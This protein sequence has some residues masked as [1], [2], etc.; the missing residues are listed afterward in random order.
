LSCWLLDLCNQSGLTGAPLVQPTPPVTL[1]SSGQE[2]ATGRFRLR[3]RVGSRVRD[4]KD[5]Q[6]TQ[7]T[8]P[9]KPSF[10]FLVH[11]PSASPFARI[12]PASLQCVLRAGAG[13][14]TWE[15]GIRGSPRRTRRR[16]RRREA[17]GPTTWWS[18]STGSSG[19]TDILYL[20]QVTLIH[21]ASRLVS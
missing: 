19:G 18:W 4:S 10:P 6:A 5:K 20:F 2:P 9:Y 1:Q 8:D 17:A 3:L 13:W 16:R 15:E 14:V 12:P 11:P 21:S 7:R